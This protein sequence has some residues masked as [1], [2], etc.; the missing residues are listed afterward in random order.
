MGEYWLFV[1]LN[2][3]TGEILMHLN[4]QSG[5]GGM[6]WG[7]CI[8]TF[9]GHHLLELL[10]NK[11]CPPGAV[12]AVISDYGDARYF[13][14]GFNFDF[15]RDDAWDRA[16]DT[17]C[18]GFHP[19][20]RRM[21]MDLGLTCKELME[22]GDKVAMNK[23]VLVECTGGNGRHLTAPD[24][25]QIGIYPSWNQ[26]VLIAIKC[27]AKLK[28]K[29][30]KLTKHEGGSRTDYLNERR[31]IAAVISE[32]YSQGWCPTTKRRRAGEN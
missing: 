30:N 6:K 1:C 14:E 24:L 23:K 18:I 29:M 17:H 2:R 21:A 31:R 9:H 8:G 25:K 10:K 26:N 28:M 20:L 15:L 3:T 12:W 22:V 5:F 7:E 27:V 19:T 32:A 13:P 4:P 16:C 11:F